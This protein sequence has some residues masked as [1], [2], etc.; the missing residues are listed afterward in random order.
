M[1]RGAASLRRVP[2]RKVS[3]K[4]KRE[5]LIYADKR[6]WF[7]AKPENAACPVAAS[8]LIKVVPEDAEPRAHHRAAT[9][10]HHAWKRGKYFLD[11]STFLAVSH[12]GHMWIENNKDEAR[13]R[14]WL[15][16]TAETRAR[17]LAKNK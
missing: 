15:C 10:V 3:G 7:L 16:D 1:K 4:R 6:R 5:N 11:E 17:W 12:D 9:E 2:I 14:G 8:G 13:A